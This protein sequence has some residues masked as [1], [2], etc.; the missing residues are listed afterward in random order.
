MTDKQK[1]FVAEY[2]VDLNATAACIRAGYSERNADKIGSQLLGKSRI[3]QAIQQAQEKR[4]EK[5]NLSAEWV[6][7]R[8]KLISDRCIQ[9]EPIL[10]TKGHETGEWKFD[11]AGANKATEMIGKH[12]GMFTDKLELGGKGGGPLI[13]KLEG[14]LKEWAK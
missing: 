7:E 9:G 6:L 5:I 3:S 1:M 4:A 8:F 13:V 14:D 12:L 11:S 10:D 2:L